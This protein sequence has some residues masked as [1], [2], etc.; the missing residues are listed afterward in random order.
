MTIFSMELHLSFKIFL[1]R[2]DYLILLALQHQFLIQNQKLNSH[3]IYNGMLIHRVVKYC[4]SNFH[5]LYR[6]TAK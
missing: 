2:V 5:S 6:K 4:Y 3:N 1:G